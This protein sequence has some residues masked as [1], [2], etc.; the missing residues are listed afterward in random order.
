MPIRK[1]KVKIR[2]KM[3][4]DAISQELASQFI[5]AIYSAVHNKTVTDMNEGDELDDVVSQSIEHQGMAEE[6]LRMGS[7]KIMVNLAV[8]ISGSMFRRLGGIS[9][10]VPAMTMMRIFVKAFRIIEESLPAD[11]FDYRVWL[12]AALSGPAFF[13][14]GKD[15]GIVEENSSFSKWFDPGFMK[16]MPVDKILSDVMENKSSMSGGGTYL[17]PV[18]AKWAEL[19][20][21]RMST[22]K[23]DIVFTDGGLFDTDGV[24]MSQLFRQSGKYMGLIYTVG[25]YQHKL[26]IGFLGY[27]VAPNEIQKVTERTLTDFVQSTLY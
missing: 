18:I 5:G 21:Q 12:W 15:K 27:D 11:V 26:P 17:A 8:D 3:T 23:L 13:Q 19:D 20:M 22:H 4:L 24:S 14:L 25:A 7:T 16:D 1:T 9:A 2:K 6:L 10:I